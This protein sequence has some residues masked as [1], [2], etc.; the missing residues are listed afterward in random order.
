[1]EDMAVLAALG[2]FLMVLFLILI[3]L[4]LVDAIARYKYLKVRNYPNPWMGFIPIANVYACVEATYG[5]VNYINLYGWRAPAV[6]LKLWGIVTYVLTVVCNQIPYV[7]GFLSLVV[8]I[9]N[10]AVL[11]QIFRDMM[12]RLDD[13]QTVGFAVLANIISIIASIKL[14]TTAG[15]RAPGSQDWQTDPR[16]LESQ[17]VIDGPL[18]FMNGS[19]GG[20]QA[21]YTYTAPQNPV[22]PEAPVEPA[23]P[24]EFTPAAPETPVQGFTADEAPVA[25]EAP[26]APEAPVAPE[27]PAAPELNFTTDDTNQQ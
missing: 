20:A 21:G 18:S 26:E 14:L 7:G 15:N 13:P 10:I 1:M 6:L 3:A 25:P 8:T 11:V 9:I 22:A 16:V 2:G 4:Y 23:A 27:A 19:N 24:A 12:E 5:P 17:K